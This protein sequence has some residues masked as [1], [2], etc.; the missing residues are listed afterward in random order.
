MITLRIVNAER[1]MERLRKASTAV[2]ATLAATVRDEALRTGRE[3]REY[4]AGPRVSDSFWGTQPGKAPY[5]T[6][7]TANTA[8][9]LVGGDE[10]VRIQ[11]TSGTLYRAVVGHPARYVAALEAG[12]RRGS[13]N[14]RIPTAAAMT[15]AGVD[16]MA[17]RSVRGRPEFKLVV[18]KGRDGKRRAWIVSFK[19]EGRRRKMVLMYLIKR[20]ER[21]Q[22][23]GMFKR[24]A[25]NADRRMP[26]NLRAR[27]Q[28][29]V[30]A[31]A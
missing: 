9:A 24:A 15:D 16:R 10:V 22:P 26:A 18:L 5:I 4:L 19:G 30:S 12:D 31:F 17:G 29:T 2:G 8:R 27:V 1:T 13:G 3:I 11:T 20:V 7:R 6:R 21:F 25:A 23:R 14:A 28:R